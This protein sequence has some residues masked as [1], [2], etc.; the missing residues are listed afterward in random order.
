M[1]RST[2]WKYSLSIR[3]IF[4]MSQLI[5]TMDPQKPKSFMPAYVQDTIL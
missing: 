2:I 3:G 1:E 5:I 4:N